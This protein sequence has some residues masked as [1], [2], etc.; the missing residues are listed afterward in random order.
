[1]K[2]KREFKYVAKDKLLVLSYGDM[3]KT[4]RNINSSELYQVMD[5]YCWRMGWLDV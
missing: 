3:V 2:K 5:S 4:Y 1:M